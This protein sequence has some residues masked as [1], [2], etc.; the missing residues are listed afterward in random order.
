M[1]IVMLDKV[2]TLGGLHSRLVFPSSVYPGK[3]GHQ[4]AT[5][6]VNSP[7]EVQVGKQAQLNVRDL[8]SLLRAEAVEF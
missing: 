8:G 7:A 2:L 5:K 6:L 4:T 3:R 1:G